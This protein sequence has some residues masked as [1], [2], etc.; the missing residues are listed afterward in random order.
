[1]GLLNK[2]ASAAEKEAFWCSQM[3]KVNEA[4]EKPRQR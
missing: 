3:K 4:Y 1:M 2:E